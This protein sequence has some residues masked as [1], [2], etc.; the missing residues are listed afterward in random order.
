MSI[1]PRMLVP[2]ND[3]KSVRFTTTHR[4]W[5]PIALEASW[6]QG[7][8]VPPLFEALRVF[9][10]GND[11]V[12]AATICGS[13]AGRTVCGSFD[14]APK[15]FTAGQIVTLALV[16]RVYQHPGCIRRNVA[17]INRAHFCFATRRL[18]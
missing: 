18:K 2:I 14:G 6:I 17:C 5:R 16:A 4:F 12:T 13:I 9:K 11:S 8:N 15:R 3:N 10:F 7:S 1:T